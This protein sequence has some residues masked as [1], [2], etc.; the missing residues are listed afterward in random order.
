MESLTFTMAVFIS[1]KFNISE[2]KKNNYIF[3]SWDRVKLSDNVR[4]MQ[5]Y[6]SGFTVDQLYELFNI[7]CLKLSGGNNHYLHVDAVVRAFKAVHYPAP[8]ELPPRS[9]RGDDPTTTH[10]DYL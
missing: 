6:L 4:T 2:Y 1:T 8:Y 3:T 10:G 7:L 9:S 5:R